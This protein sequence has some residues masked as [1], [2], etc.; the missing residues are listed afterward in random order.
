MIF[1]HKPLSESIVMREFEK[2]A[3]KKGLAKGSVISKTASEVEKLDLNPSNNLIIDMLNLAEGLRVKGFEKE[4]ESLEG[5]VLAYKTEETNL[6]RAIDEDAD[7]MLDFA[8]PKKN[9][10]KFEAKDGHGDFEDTRSQHEKMIAIINKKVASD[11]NLV[12]G[13]T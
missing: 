9:K 12:L 8:H 2:V 11:L 6:Y 3:I 13:E 10:V 1:K 5:K 4:A 7:D